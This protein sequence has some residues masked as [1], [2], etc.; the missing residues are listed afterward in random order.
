MKN[1]FIPIVI[2][3]SMFSCGNESTKNVKVEKT[4]KKEL[5]VL[6]VDELLENQDDLIGKEVIV[7]GTVDHVCKHSGKKAFIFGSKEDVR[8][9]VEAGDIVGGFD[10]DLIGNDIEVKGILTEF[11]IDQDYVNK[12]ESDLE[13]EHKEG[14][15]QNHDG[16]KEYKEKQEKIKDLCNE[17]ASTEKGYKSLIH[18]E[19][20]SFHES[21]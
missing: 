5:V 19:G 7:K 1:I 20:I 16:D 21:K 11:R 14:E 2:A 17:I 4:E 10:A 3:I 8:I 12:L 9:K 6:T 13:A 15:E 18:V